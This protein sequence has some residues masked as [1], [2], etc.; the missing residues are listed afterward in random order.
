METITGNISAASEAKRK[1]E[2]FPVASLLLPRKV[3]A[4]VV[5]LYRF[6]RHADD[7]ADDTTLDSEVRLTALKHADDVLTGNVCG[8]DIPLW[9]RGYVDLINSGY[10]TRRQGR[11]LLSA[12]MQDVSKSRYTNWDELIDYCQRSAAPVGRAMLELHQEWEA[13]MVASD[14]LCNA[15]QI[16]NH[17]QDLKEDY[18][19]RDRVYFPSSWF[20]NDVSVL[21]HDSSTE[22]VRLAINNALD[23]VDKLLA[24]ANNLPVTVNST[25]LR[26]EI[27]TILNIARLLSLKLRQ[28]DPLD[29][30][31]KLSK[32]TVLGCFLRGIA[33]SLVT[34]KSQQGYAMGRTRGSS[35]FLPLLRLPKDRRKAMFSLYAFC[36]EI[37]DAVDDA[38]DIASGKD[39]IAFW[40]SEVS[41][42]FNDSDVTI[43]PKHP[44][45]RSLVLLKNRYALEQDYFS[46][47]LAGQEMDLHGVVKPSFEELELYCYRV[48]SCVGLLSIPIFGCNNNKAKKYAEYLGKGMQM[49]NIARD[50]VEDARRGRIYLPQEWLDDAGIGDISA[51]D[52]ALCTPETS[53]NLSPVVERLC[54]KAK[55]HLQQAD[56]ML[57]IE[58]RSLM[59]PARLMRRIYTRYLVALEDINYQPMQHKLRLSLATKLMALMSRTRY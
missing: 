17:L 33:K 31:V 30:K 32:M 23:K 8:A 19:D 3:R 7:I 14:A 40:N 13:D 51:D 56:A 12:F 5:A 48:A 43:Y 37:D 27:L 45:T 38:P 57:D 53:K 50:V 10:A 25:R 41:Y 49:I 34:T 16:L 29:H 9:A 24:I 44:V 15:L 1:K 46:E 20:D 52:I 6:A 36:R 47:M 22:K 2:N 18:R 4:R 55:E 58:D 11:A 35:F 28:E 54:L 39:N 26:A 42:L 59:L 21:G